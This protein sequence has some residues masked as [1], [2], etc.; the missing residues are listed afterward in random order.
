MTSGIEEI[1]P[2]QRSWQQVVEQLQAGRA[3]ESNAELDEFEVALQRTMRPVH[4]PVEFREG[5]RNNLAV[6][7]QRRFVGLEVEAKQSYSQGLLMGA[8]M[9]LS[10]AVVGAILYLLLR[11]HRKSAEGT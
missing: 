4:A 8:T 7:A 9:G 5:L 6:A 3:K 1:K 10:A 11:P 2:P